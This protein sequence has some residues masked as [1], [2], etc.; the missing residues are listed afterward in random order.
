MNCYKIKHILTG[1]YPNGQPRVTITSTGGLVE[2]LSEEDFF[3]GRT[4]PRN[5]ELMR[6]FKDVELVDELGSG[7]KR[8]LEAY[9]RSVFETTPSFIIVT[10]HCA[11][12][13]ER[14]EEEI[15]KETSGKENGT[16]SGTNGTVNDVS[17]I[18]NDTISE[19]DVLNAL[20]ASPQ[21]T[22]DELAG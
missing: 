8:I 21:A 15:A 22:Y 9:D 6:V 7:M 1:D 14:S 3:S 10:F 2:G 17:G 11:S 16:D 19:N 4:M 5:R 12:G 18:I 13:F 20:K